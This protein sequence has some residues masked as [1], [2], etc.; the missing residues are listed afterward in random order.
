MTQDYTTLLGMNDGRIHK[1]YVQLTSQCLNVVEASSDV[2]NTK[3]W[4]KTLNEYEEKKHTLA[5]RMV[6]TLEEDQK[7]ERKAIAAAG[8]SVAQALVSNQDSK[9]AASSCRLELETQQVADDAIY[10]GASDDVTNVS[11]NK[12]IPYNTYLM[13]KSDSKNHIEK[14]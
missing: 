11:N 4:L 7:A 8:E 14:K 13:S 9:L 3:L 5:Q 1:K 12:T 6:V 10:I 2:L